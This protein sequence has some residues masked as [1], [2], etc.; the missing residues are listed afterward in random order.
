MRWTRSLGGNLELKV[1]GTLGEGPKQTSQEDKTV[2]S[3]QE[4]GACGGDVFENIK[5]VETAK[6]EDVEDKMRNY[7]G[8]KR[9][10]FLLA[11]AQKL[12]AQLQAPKDGKLEG[13]LDHG[14][15]DV[16]VED[17]R[18]FG[19]TMQED[20]LISAIKNNKQE[21]QRMASLEAK[22]LEE[23]NIQI[24]KMR[25]M[26]LKE[27][28]EKTKLELELAFVKSQVEKLGREKSEVSN[29]A[30][31]VELKQLRKELASQSSRIVQC[32]QQL[33][34]IER[35]SA[36][37]D[38]QQ[39]KMRLEDEEAEGR[40]LKQLKAVKV[41]HLEESYVEV[42]NQ[43]RSRRDAAESVL[44][45]FTS[46]GNF[47][48]VEAARSALEQLNAALAALEVDFRERMSSVGETR[49]TESCQFLPWSRNSLLL[50]A[51][52]SPYPWSYRLL[53]LLFPLAGR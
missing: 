43:L 11:L 13:N 35:E 14:D 52:F 34:Q 6:P 25:Q 17:G 26:L 36:I 29:K 10:A 22:H 20:K 50:S 45:Q 7:E 4:E 46:F 18:D 40:W 39:L 48:A 49:L 19:K 16:E 3:K 41:K 23:H 47:A 38:E 53:L 24:S 33:D 8:K 2:I 12:R 28:N 5:D 51:S 37:L 27:T 15:G 42:G 9:V 32:E 1:N 31:E 44:R 30:K 21:L